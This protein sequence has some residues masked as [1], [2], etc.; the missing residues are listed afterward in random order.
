VE[1]TCCP[2]A[3]AFE[4]GGLLAIFGD[5]DV[6]DPSTNEDVE[7]SPV[8]RSELVPFEDEDE[9]STAT[10]VADSET[11]EFIR[12]F[13]VEIDVPFSIETFETD[14]EPVMVELIEG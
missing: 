10:V 7:I 3:V 9:F 5:C 8:G 11:V 12:P 14:V 6:V 1:L 13:E 4:A 2:V